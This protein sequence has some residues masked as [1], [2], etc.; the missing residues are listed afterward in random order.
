MFASRFLF[1]KANTIAQNARFMSSGHSAA[2]VKKEVALWYKIS[3]G[4]CISAC[5]S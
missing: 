1:K 2:E 5:E 4:N 3:Y